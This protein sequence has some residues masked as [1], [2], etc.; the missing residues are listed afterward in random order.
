MTSE[1]TPQQ[2]GQSRRRDTPD[3]VAAAASSTPSMNPNAVDLRDRQRHDAINSETPPWRTPPV[4]EWG[5]G[6]FIRPGAAPTTP[7][8]HHDLKI[9]NLTTERRN[10]VPSP[11]CCRN[12]GRRERGPAHRPV[13]IGGK[14]SPR[15]SRLV[16]AA[17]ARVGKQMGLTAITPKHSSL[18]CLVTSNFILLGPWPFR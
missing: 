13:E 14:E 11:S 8:T 5:W 7:M 1:T 9:Q 3:G 17:A 4:W 2:R 6:R 10:G 18:N 15:P 12:S 16:A